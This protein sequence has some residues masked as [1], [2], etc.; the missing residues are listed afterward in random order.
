MKEGAE[1]GECYYVG[2]N[3]VMD[4]NARKL[5]GKKARKQFR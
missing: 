4:P 2:D 3:M 1:K 5:I